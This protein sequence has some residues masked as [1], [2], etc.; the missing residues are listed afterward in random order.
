MLIEVVRAGDKVLT[1]KIVYANF[2]CMTRR[3]EDVGLVMRCR[4]STAKSR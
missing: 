2:G 3:P 1:G 4:T